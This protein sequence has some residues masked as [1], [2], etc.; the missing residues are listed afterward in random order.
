MKNCKPGY[1]DEDGYWFYKQT[2]ENMT[3]LETVNAI[4]K[5][6]DRE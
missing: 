5:N 2:L 3:E 1:V 6:G 4:L